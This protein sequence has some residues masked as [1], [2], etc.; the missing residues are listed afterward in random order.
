MIKVSVIVPVFNVERYLSACL[1]S[2]LEQSLEEIE[3]ICVD[4]GST[5]GSADILD[6]YAIMDKRIQVIHK[7]NSGYGQSMNIGMEVAK[8][9]YIGIVESDDYILPNMYERLYSTAKEHDLDIVKSE[10]IF[11]WDTVGYTYTHHQWR[12]E[13]YYNRV[14]DA[15]QRR[16]F[17]VFLMNTWT[18]IYKKTFLETHS[19]KHNET[20]GA[21]YQDNGFWFQTMSLAERAMWL[22]EGFYMYRQDNPDSSI[23]SK[24][25]VMTMA[26]E[27]D[28]IERILKKNELTY[29]L[30][31]CHYYRMI[32]HK[33][34]FLRIS[35]D[36]KREYCKEIALDFQKYGELTVQNK[37]VH[38]W[39]KQL[40]DNPD[41]FCRIFIE[42][43]AK[44]L[45][46]IENA[47]HIIIYGAGKCGKKAFRILSHQGLSDKILC[48]AI[49]D[50]NAL[51][52]VGTI[53][54][55]CID[56]LMEHRKNALVVIGANKP[57]GDY[58]GAYRQMHEKLRG[59]KFDNVMDLGVLNTYFYYVK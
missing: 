8:G 36:L 30:E 48:F 4:D 12:W 29:E 13:R 24:S 42:N 2:V 32:R 53:P 35:D 55:R 50:N 56:D 7:E 51:G 16:I 38:N 47:E 15:S 45:Q 9:E 21:S 6:K 39:L 44:A 46:Q 52:N 34:A 49:S 41:E 37:K 33:G 58:Y 18:G 54:I 3:I 5:D 1:D 59:L 27:Y 19:I 40:Y 10:C 25:K 20:P 23:K 57:A 14:L 11:W 22:D 17:F 26:R 28:F 31:L 43:K